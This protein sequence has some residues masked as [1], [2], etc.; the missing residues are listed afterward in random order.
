MNTVQGAAAAVAPS[1]K[2]IRKMTDYEVYIDDDRYRVPSLYLIT[3]ASDQHARRVVEE[4]WR[5]S[6]HHLGAELRRDGERL[7]GL[8]SLAE[9]VPAN[10]RAFESNSSAA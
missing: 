8:G 4:L 6:E 10:R 3:A 5:S 2:M 1:R 7:E 9:G